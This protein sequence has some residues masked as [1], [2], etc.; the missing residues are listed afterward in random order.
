MKNIAKF[1]LLSSSLRKINLTKAELKTMVV[2][3]LAH[4]SSGWTPLG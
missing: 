3:A 1:V 4:K 2:P